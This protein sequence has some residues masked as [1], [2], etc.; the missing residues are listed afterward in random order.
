MFNLFKKKPKQTK[1]FTQLV[2][3]MR[4]KKLQIE[5]LKKEMKSM[6]KLMFDPSTGKVGVAPEKKVEQKSQE[7]KT[8]PPLPPQPVVETPVQPPVPR[9]PEP[10][11]Q[12]RAAPVV[13]QP[14][15]VVE[16]VE[17]AVE[18]EPE[19]PQVVTVKI[20]FAL[21]SGTFEMP[22]PLL[23]EEAEAFLQA[24]DAAVDQQR[25]MIIGTS[26][27]NTRF[28]LRYDIEVDQ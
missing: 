19:Q 20:V 2:N 21:P 26:R 15:P 14:T 4:V 9:A 7:Q 3:E 10:V 13:K 17:E 25:I 27:I 11:A 16:E 22:V 28:I 6:A 18:E 24:L 1:E 23:L 12:P 5:K 8:P